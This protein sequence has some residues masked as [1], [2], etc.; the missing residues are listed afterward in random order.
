MSS[1]DFPLLQEMND[2]E[3]S[4]SH[5]PL[6]QHNNNN[7]SSS[8]GGGDGSSLTGGRSPT[9]IHTPRKR[10]ATVSTL[11][12]PLPMRREDSEMDFD[13][14]IMAGSPHRGRSNGRS[15]TPPPSGTTSPSN[16]L[17]HPTTTTSRSGSR[18][19]VSP[20]MSRTS[21]FERKLSSD[22]DDI[23]EA[24]Q[25]GAG[26]GGRGTGTGSDSASRQ[27]QALA[28]VRS[29]ADDLDV[30][31]RPLSYS[32]PGAAL[33]SPG[34]A[35]GSAAQGQDPL[36]RHPVAYGTV[37]N[38]SFG[39]GITPQPT[40]LPPTMSMPCPRGETVLKLRPKRIKRVSGYIFG[41]LMGEGRHGHVRDALDLSR[42][43]VLRVAVKTIS[44]KNRPESELQK[45]AAV[46]GNEVH[47]L[48][49]YHHANVIR[50]LDVFH[51][52]GKD[53]LV[54]PVATCSLEQL[55]QFRRNELARRLALSE[56]NSVVSG[57]SNYPTQSMSNL[58]RLSS[59]SLFPQSL[60]QDIFF[61]LLSG[62]A[63]LH[64][65]G[66]SHNDLKPANIL[67]YPDGNVRITDLGSCGDSY[68][69][70]GTP[71]FVSPQV[72]AGEIPAEK[73]NA[74]KNDAWSCGVIL[75][76]L[77]TN[78]MPYHRENEFAL[79]QSIANDP[80]NFELLPEEFDVLPGNMLS[81]TSLNHDGPP[82]MTGHDG[83]NVSSFRGSQRTVSYR[84]T[85]ET[86]EHSVYL[87]KEAQGSPASVK[88]LLRGL[89]EKDETKRLS[90]AEALQHPWFTSERSRE[91]DS[92]QLRG[93]GKANTGGDT[94][95]KTT[96]DEAAK[97]VKRRMF[98]VKEL[99]EVVEADE[100]RHLQFVCTAMHAAGIPIPSMAFLPEAVYERRAQRRAL[101]LASDEDDDGYE[102]EA[103]RS[104]MLDDPRNTTAAARKGPPLLRESVRTTPG[105]LSANTTGGGQ[106]S[107]RSLATNPSQGAPPSSPYIKEGTVDR[108]KFLTADELF[109]YARKN[110]P[111][112]DVRTMRGEPHAKVLLQ[113]Y[114][115]AFIVHTVFGVP[116]ENG[117]KDVK[118]ANGQGVDEGDEKRLCCCSVM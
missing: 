60:I 71:A 21:P 44:R 54:L 93:V 11:T 52:D 110:Q 24:L 107:T 86:K 69:G 68:R 20:P 97:G 5:L 74:A 49:R 75:F 106:S 15:R 1:L 31:R 26:G 13:G 42:Q 72:A 16:N 30:L 83:V 22:D 12:I 114:A 87:M 32:F 91:L 90:V 88:S 95:K 37:S 35:S 48:Q 39:R 19:G 61:Q 102:S 34:S 103:P 66:V 116:E 101:G 17:L 115:K 100:K 82:T 50:A 23:F 40:P 81:N 10:G 55:V 118:A 58:A 53:Y 36:L 33:S 6:H 25:R 78:M 56:T 65:Q 4:S 2:D 57:Y 80:I 45:L 98:N 84:G 47:H 67:L 28:S 8:G 29:S 9:L 14:A 18:F 59:R 112:A 85:R 77:L 108:G 96:I 99:A 62:V 111:N 94:T 43:E 38:R 63:Y 70:R 117:K 92:Q 27:P 46:L 105:T 76:Y 73:I 89:L 109:H 104:L 79:Y 113:T 51:R 64:K 41:P 7:I 3:P